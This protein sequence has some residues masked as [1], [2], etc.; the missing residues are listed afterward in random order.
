ML[1]FVKIVNYFYKCKCF[2]YIHIVYNLREHIWW[3][4]A[5]WNKGKNT[6]IVVSFL[7]LNL[8]QQKAQCC[9]QWK[10]V[11]WHVFLG[12]CWSSRSSRDSRDSRNCRNRSETGPPYLTLSLLKKVLTSSN[13]KMACDIF[14]PRT[15]CTAKELTTAMSRDGKRSFTISRFFMDL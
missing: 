8:P 15:L 5:P 7:F 9:H 12:I 11:V 14:L 3:C 10:G 6:Q 13:L 4:D 2:F 1:F